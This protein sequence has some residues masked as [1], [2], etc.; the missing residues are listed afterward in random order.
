VR[1]CAQ[2]AVGP[3]AD[4]RPH[5]REIGQPVAQELPGGGHVVGSSGVHTG[6]NGQ[7]QDLDEERALGAD[8]PATPAA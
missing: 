1:S 6:G 4:D 8:R 3:V 5:A 7:A 2:A